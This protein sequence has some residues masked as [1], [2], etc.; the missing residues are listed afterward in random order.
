MRMYAHISAPIRDLTQGMSDHAWRRCT[1]HATA[2]RR[3]LLNQVALN[4]GPCGV[5]STC[6]S[7]VLERFLSAAAVLATALTLGGATGRDGRSGGAAAESISLKMP[8][9]QQG[10][11]WHLPMD[12]V[13]AI[14]T[15]EIITKGDFSF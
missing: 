11:S 5:S 7:S 12:H 15:V 6:S 3:V 1:G 4:A 8:Q 9:T 14:T 10:S 13:T 2:G